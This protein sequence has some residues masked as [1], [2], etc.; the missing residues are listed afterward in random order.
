MSEAIV[1]VEHEKRGFTKAYSVAHV[2]VEIPD[3]GFT[4]Y[5]IPSEN[6][7]PETLEKLRLKGEKTIRTVIEKYSQT[8]KTAKAPKKKKKK[9]AVAA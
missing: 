7:T 6:V 5:M 8:R 2:K 9:R 1:T 3:L 4:G